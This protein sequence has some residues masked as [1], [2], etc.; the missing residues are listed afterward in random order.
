MAMLMLPSSTPRHSPSCIL[1]PHLIPQPLTNQPLNPFTTLTPPPFVPSTQCL[2]PLPLT[3]FTVQPIHLRLAQAHKTLV[4]LHCLEDLAGQYGLLHLKYS[5]QATTEVCIS[6]PRRPSMVSVTC[7]PC[8]SHWP[9]I[10][11]CVHT[12]WVSRSKVF[13]VVLMCTC[14]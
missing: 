11:C 9:A 14:T 10:H 12:A 1:T 13:I 5:Y 8:F 2:I 7:S 6:N 4:D 3:I